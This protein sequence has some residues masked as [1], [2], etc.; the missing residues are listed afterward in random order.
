MHD[1]Y[2]LCFIHLH[3]YYDSNRNT[4]SS[5]LL[6]DSMLNTSYT[7]NI[8]INTFAAFLRASNNACKTISATFNNHKITRQDS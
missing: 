4:R 2:L 3:T 7:A 8:T 1:C 6:S 5:Y